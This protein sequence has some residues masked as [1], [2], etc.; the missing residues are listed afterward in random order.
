MSE[1]KLKKKIKEFFKFLKESK[2][3]V[4]STANE[5]SLFG[6]KISEIEK[7]LED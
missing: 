7:L 6:Q 5:L 1:E 2:I 4:T 3:E